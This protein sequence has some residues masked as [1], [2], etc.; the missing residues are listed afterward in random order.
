[1]QRSIIIFM[2]AISMI[3]CENN[4][5]DSDYDSRSIYLCGNSIGNYDKPYYSVNGEITYLSTG[6][7]EG[8]AN[9]MLVYGDDVYVVGQEYESGLALNYVAKIWKNGEETWITNGEEYS[10]AEDV[11]IY[12]STIFVLGY[13]GDSTF[14]WTDGI[15]K[16]LGK[17]SRPRKICVNDLDTHIIARFDYIK[18]GINTEIEYNDS[19]EQLYDLSLFGNDVH[20]I[21]E[22]FIDNNYYACYW[23]NGKATILDTSKNFSSAKSMFIYDSDIYIAGY[24]YNEGSDNIEAVYWNNGK[25]VW[26]TGGKEGSRAST[27]YVYKGD[28]YVGGILNPSGSND[29]DQFLYWKN[30]KEV[31]VSHEISSIYVTGK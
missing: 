13:D 17:M 23:K 15:T 9:D 11:F 30:G 27:I 24:S 28:V 22:V 5:V 18:N 20:I 25:K 16:K 31:F 21:G 2:I 12:D 19:I 7:K 10:D 14:C 1:M 8:S 29:D 6:I 4:P 3:K 26:L